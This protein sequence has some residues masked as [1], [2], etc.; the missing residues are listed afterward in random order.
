MVEHAGNTTRFGVGAHVLRR[1]VTLTGPAPRQA[2]R[3][4]EK[5]NSICVK[6]GEGGVAGR[7]L[8]GR[9]SCVSCR[10][11]PTRGGHASARHWSS[12]EQTDADVCE[13]SEPRVCVLVHM[14]LCCARVAA[15]GAQHGGGEP[16]VRREHL[17]L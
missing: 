4:E 1:P 3:P 10:R 8:A 13:P 17:A 11:S 16:Q 14:R 15:D 6:G 12:L 2:G 9:S 5:L 7:A